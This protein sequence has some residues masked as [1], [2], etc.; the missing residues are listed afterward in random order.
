MQRFTSAWPLAERYEALIRVFNDPAPYAKRLAARLH[1]LPH[2]AAEL[3]RLPK[4]KRP[5][6]SGEV[7]DIADLI[8]PESFAAAT[9]AAE[10]AWANSS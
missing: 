10:T 6:R 2:R 7:A 5:R 9:Q 8:G 4:R 3:L 1:A